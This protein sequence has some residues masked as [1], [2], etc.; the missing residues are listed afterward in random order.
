MI[1]LT[2]TGV[3]GVYQEKIVSGAEIGEGLSGRM[4]SNAAGSGKLA[5]A[6]LRVVKNLAP[7]ADSHP[8]P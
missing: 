6:P 5:S 3:F 2:A 8:E 1:I 7:L 4:D